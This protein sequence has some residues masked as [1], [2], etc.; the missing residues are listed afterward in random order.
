MRETHLNKGI[1]EHEDFVKAAFRID[2]QRL[3]NMLLPFTLRRHGLHVNFFLR[4]HAL[5]AWVHALLTPVKRLYMEFLAYRNRVNYQMEHTGQVI[6]LEKVLNDHFDDKNRIRIQ[7]GPK[8]DWTYIYRTDERKPKYLKTMYLHSQLSYG[9]HGADFNVMIPADISIWSD[10][11]HEAECR[12]LL[13]YYKL[14]GKTYQ[15]IKP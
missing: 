9:D 4:R 8:L 3:V 15:L 6:Y 13:N 5:I 14:A 12:S 7:D 10:S 1:A 2:Y 11:G